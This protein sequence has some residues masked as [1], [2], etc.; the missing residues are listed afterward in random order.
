MKPQNLP[1]KLIWYYILGTY[2]IYYIGGLYLFAP[3]L[4]I[5]LSLYLLKQWWLQTPNTPA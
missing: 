5:F 3:L 4:A 2:P 1:E